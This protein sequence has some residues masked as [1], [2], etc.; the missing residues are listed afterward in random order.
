MKLLPVLMYALPLLDM[1]LLLLQRS[2]MRVLIYNQAVLVPYLQLVTKLAAQ[3]SYWSRG[4]KGSKASR[5]AAAA[6]AARLEATAAA[7]SAAAEPVEFNSN[8][9]SSGGDVGQQSRRQP[10]W[11][12]FFARSISGRL[13]LRMEYLLATGRQ[14]EVRSRCAFSIHG[15]K[16][17]SGLCADG[18]GVLG[19]IISEN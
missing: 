8:S 2:N 7:E 19:F 6:A 9:S 10:C 13:P 17:F 4:R 14:E 1:L 18:P 16:G 15:M 12:I 5:A 11:Q 3:S